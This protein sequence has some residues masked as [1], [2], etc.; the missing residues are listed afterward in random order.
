MD[1][2][3]RDVPASSAVAQFLDETYPDSFL[4][5]RY[6]NMGILDEIGW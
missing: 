3:R 1:Q 2:R 5:E 4:K 6:P